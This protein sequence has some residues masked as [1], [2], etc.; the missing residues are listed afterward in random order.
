MIHSW[1][2]FEAAILPGNDPIT[3]KDGVLCFGVLHL[4]EAISKGVEDYLKQLET[5]RN[6][7]TKTLNRNRDLKR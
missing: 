5:N 2:L 4:R 3:K 1:N 7:Q 6:L